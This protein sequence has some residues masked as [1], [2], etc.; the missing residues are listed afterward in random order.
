MCHSGFTIT[1]LTPT[2]PPQRLLRSQQPKKK[3]PS[4]TGDVFKLQYS[5]RCIFVLIAFLVRGALSNARYN[6]GSGKRA[7]E[8][9]WATLFLPQSD[10]RLISYK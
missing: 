6:N 5:Q 9:N 8:I 7:R 1:I 10:L 2:T 4:S 3:E